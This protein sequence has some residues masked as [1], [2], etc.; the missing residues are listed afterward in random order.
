[1]SVKFSPFQAKLRA[2]C[3]LR[4]SGLKIQ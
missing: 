1:M 4:E 2:R 3:G